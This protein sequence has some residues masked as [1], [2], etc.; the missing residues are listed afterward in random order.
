MA[1]HSLA[2]NSSNIVDNLYLVK[3]TPPLAGEA[4]Y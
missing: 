4:L 3:D 2:K 1:T